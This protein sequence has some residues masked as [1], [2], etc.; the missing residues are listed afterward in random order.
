MVVE[1]PEIIDE[2]LLDAFMGSLALSELRERFKIKPEDFKTRLDLQCYLI[3]LQI[4][5]TDKDFL[6]PISGKPKMGKSTLGIWIGIKTKDALRKEFHVDIPEFDVEKDIHYTPISEKELMKIINDEKPSM[7]MFDRAIFDDATLSGIGFK[8]SEIKDLKE[9]V[10]VYFSNMKTRKRGYNKFENDVKV[11]FE[12]SFIYDLI[13][14]NPLMPDKDYKEFCDV[15]I[16][17]FDSAL[18]VQCK[19]SALE[20]PERLTKATIVDGL[21]QLK[22]S[23]NK[24]KSKSERL[25]MVNS[26]KIFKD[27]VFSDMK[28]FYPILVVNRKLPFL[29]Y[30]AINNTPEIKK[31]DFVPIILSIDD[32]KFLVSEL[33]TPT[34]LF[35]VSSFPC[36]HV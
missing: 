4:T 8:K 3:A 5:A 30:N 17:F 26:I 31:L 28:R 9:G 36:F 18:I 7:K 13:F 35:V 19:E 23:M 25:F 6:I 20:D 27:Y 33:N 21:N 14:T 29:D 32:L 15:L 16:T 34:D 2:H 1:K 24:A 10:V 11:V 12:N 22:T